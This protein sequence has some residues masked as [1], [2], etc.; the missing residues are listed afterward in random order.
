MESV[1]SVGMIYREGV[2]SWIV[3]VGMRGTSCW[4]TLVAFTSAQVSSVPRWLRNLEKASS[5]FVRSLGGQSPS[6]PGG[7]G[8]FAWGRGQSR[9]CDGAG[10]C[11]G[12][13]AFGAELV[14]SVERRW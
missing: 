5:A 11:V 7:G 4:S 12:L 2:L 3:L 1:E 6:T 8:R 14:C 10:R 9:M 13:Q